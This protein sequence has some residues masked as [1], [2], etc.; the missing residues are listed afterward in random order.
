MTIK[1]YRVRAGC[2]TIRF[3]LPEIHVCSASD[4]DDLD[5]FNASFVELDGSDEAVSRLPK[6][7]PPLGWDPGGRRSER[8]TDVDWMSEV[9]VRFRLTVPRPTELGFVG[10]R[11]PLG[12]TRFVRVVDTISLIFGYGSSRSVLVCVP[13][14]DVPKLKDMTQDDVGDLLFLAGDVGAPSWLTYESGKRAK[15]GGL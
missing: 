4:I 2:A 7:L 9:G 13:L 3:C 8:L 15:E 12:G 1:V 5:A 6:R 14:V 10:C 11:K